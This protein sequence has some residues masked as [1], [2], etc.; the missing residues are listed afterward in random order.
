MRSRSHRVLSRW[1]GLT[2]LSL[3]SIILLPACGSSQKK[4]AKAPTEVVVDNEDEFSEDGVE[5]SQEFGGMSED[6]VTKAF[7]RLQPDLIDCLTVIGASRDYLV[8]QVA[9]LV[10]VDHTGKAISAHM[11]QSNLGSYMA[12][13]CML[14]V[15]QASSWPK[16]VGGR[17]GLARSGME[18]DPGDVR[19]PVHWEA[20]D[21][22]STLTADKNV[23]NMAQC[24]GGG[25]FEITAYVDTHGS[26]LSAGVAHTDDKGEETAAC[27]IAAVEE[28][29]FQSPGSWRAKVSFRH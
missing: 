22:Q 24:G 13:R 3:F 26:V 5:L 29:H 19:P 18:Y 21:V 17:K 14:D 28:M 27:L 9:F 2:G 8:G 16:P 20:S 6:K 1:C 15:L 4:K 23:K 12:E 10:T 25:P 7:K 11:E